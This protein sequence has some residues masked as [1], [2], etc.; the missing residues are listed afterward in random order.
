MYVRKNSIFTASG[1]KK[2][3]IRYKTVVLVPRCPE[4]TRRPFA[5]FGRVVNIFICSIPADGFFPIFYL[6]TMFLTYRKSAEKNI[7]FWLPINFLNTYT[8]Y[9]SKLKYMQALPIWHMYYVCAA[10]QA[11]FYYIPTFTIIVQL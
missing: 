9:K 5:S 7:Q 6:F 8:W 2:S 4:T 3:L 11:S 10:Q 1:E